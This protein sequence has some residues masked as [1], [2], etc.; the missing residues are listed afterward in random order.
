MYHPQV[1]QSPILNDCLKLNIDGH[2]EPQLVPNFL[3]QVSIRELDNR[4][5]IELVYGRLK[6][7]RDAWNDIII[8]DSALR[9]LFPPQFI[10][11]SSINKVMYGCKCCI[12]AK[13]MHSSLLSRRDQYQRK[14]KDQNKNTKNRRSEEK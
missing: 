10:K 9:S 13:S 11:I 3:L 14:L 7:A 2:T 5:V 6:E 12:S 4:L 1:V 8:S